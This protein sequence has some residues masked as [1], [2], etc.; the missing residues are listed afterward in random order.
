M[1]I[2]QSI[3]KKTKLTLGIALVVQWLRL[4]AP[5]AG[6]MGSIPCQGI[7]SHMPQLKDPEYCNKDLVCP[8]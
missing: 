2:K 7:G 5:N 8:N 3:K 6:G 4:H 1:F